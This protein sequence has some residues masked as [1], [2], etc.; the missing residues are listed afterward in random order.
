ML[1]LYFPLI[2]VVM[3]KGRIGSP[4]GPDSCAYFPSRHHE[5]RVR[6]SRLLRSALDRVWCRL[7]DMAV[8]GQRWWKPATIGQRQRQK[9]LG[10]K[11]AGVA[12]TCKGITL[13]LATAHVRTNDDIGGALDG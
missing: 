13:H 7:S 6:R 3:G 9:A 8:V 1:A 10:A 5:G 2:S 4:F 12:R 11:E